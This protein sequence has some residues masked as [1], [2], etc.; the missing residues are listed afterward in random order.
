MEELQ[1]A[2]Q[3]RLGNNVARRE[4]YERYAGR[5]LALC[6]RYTGNREEAEDLLHDGFLKLFSSFGKFAWSASS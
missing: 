1:L 2:E 6:M 4:L 3:C 5:M